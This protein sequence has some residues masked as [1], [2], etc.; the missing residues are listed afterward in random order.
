[1]RTQRKEL[2]PSGPGFLKSEARDLGL[3]ERYG[4]SA[5]V[6]AELN[7]EGGDER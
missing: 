3:Y 6:E 5:I 4:V 7:E 2:S 1:M